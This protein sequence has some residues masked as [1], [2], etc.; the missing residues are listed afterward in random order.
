MSAGVDIVEVGGSSPLSPTSLRSASFG[1]ASRGENEQLSVG[2]RAEVASQHR[3][4]II[5]T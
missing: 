3:R 4:T 5:S 2:C 1:S